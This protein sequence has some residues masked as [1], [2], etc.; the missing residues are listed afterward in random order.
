MQ[1]L[2]PDVTSGTRPRSWSTPASGN[3]RARSGATR[4]RGDGDAGLRLRGLRA[5]SGPRRPRP[6][7]V[8][9]ADRDPMSARPEGCVSRYAMIGGWRPARRPKGGCRERDPRGRAVGPAPRDQDLPPAG[10]VSPSRPTRSPVSTPRPRP[11]R[12]P[13]GRPRRSSSPGTRP[14][15][16]CWSGTSPSPSGSSAAS[17]TWRSIVSTATLPPASVTGSPSTGRAS[18]GTPGPSPT[19]TS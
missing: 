19:P 10:G 17:S 15:P 14:G 5:P 2:G 13:S 11:T 7:A 16:R 18:R 9:R 6:S 1:V 8:T 3:R 12:S 4:C